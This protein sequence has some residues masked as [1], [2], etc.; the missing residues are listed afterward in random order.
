MESSDDFKIFTSLRFDPAL[1]QTANSQASS[2]VWNQTASA[3]YMLDLHRDRMLRAAQHWGWAAAVASIDG[4]EG[5]RKLE[6]VLLQATAHI[7]QIPHRLKVLLN[8]D[9]D[10]CC[11]IGTTPARP[12]ENLFP[13]QLPGPGTSVEQ[14]TGEGIVPVSTGEF[15]ILVDSNT[16][17][18]S[19]F[20][21]YKTTNRRAYDEARSRAGLSLT[22]MKDVLL[23]NPDGFVMEGSI[24]TPYFWRS[25]RWVTPPV[26]KGFNPSEGDGGND[27][28]T[29]RW[30]LENHMAVEDRVPVRS[31][32]DGE[33]CWISTGIRGFV[34]AKIRL[35]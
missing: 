22:A 19:E 18:P 30:A 6:G 29:R 9:G 14:H 7:D 5:L 33:E 4:V 34:S 21:H 16:T 28:T 24:S 12:F 26:S 11:E 20:T 35:R 10:L 8:R 25:G 2:L 23:V 17:A 13:T 3:F 15:E 31:L 1:L 32:V 27:G